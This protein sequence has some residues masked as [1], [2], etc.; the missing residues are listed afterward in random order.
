MN[1]HRVAAFTAYL[2]DINVDR[3]LGATSQAPN[4]MAVVSNKTPSDVLATSS[5]CIVIFCLERLERRG[6]AARS[7]T[8][9]KSS[10]AA[11]TAPRFW[12]VIQI[13][14]VIALV[15]QYIYYM[16]SLYR[17]L[18]MECS[19]RK[20][21]RRKISTEHIVATIGAM[22][23]LAGLSVTLSCV[24][25]MGQSLPILQK[26][27]DAVLAESVNQFVLFLFLVFNLSLLVF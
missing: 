14:R 3:F 2:T 9:C 20:G 10:F 8:S 22:T 1:V 5:A 6:F 13:L 23:K 19:C 4:A 15:M 25:C 24:F 18:L 12:N 7:S 21:C 26:G 17:E 27:I 16:K 11:L